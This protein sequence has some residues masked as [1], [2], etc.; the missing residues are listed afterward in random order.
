MLPVLLVATLSVGA[1]SPSAAR[2]P[3][4]QAGGTGSSPAGVTHIRVRDSGFDPS[5]PTIRR[6]AT[7]VFDFV[8]GHHT[9]TDNSE[10]DLY[11]SGLVEPGGS[12]T[13]FTFRAAGVYPFTCTPH[14]SMGGR[15]TVPVRA[16][17]AR[18]GAH[19][20]FTVT[21]AAVDAAASDRFVY[22]VQIRRPGETWGT[23]RRGVRLRRAA[24]TAHAGPGRYRFRARLRDPGLGESSFWSPADSILVG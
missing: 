6:G 22:D 2:V 5:T 12:S 24:F 11:D 10:L 9:A 23:W 7:V 13:P 20:R 21:W 18:G 15:V 1:G 19:R 16:A 17:P 3:A 4:P 14:P 8:E